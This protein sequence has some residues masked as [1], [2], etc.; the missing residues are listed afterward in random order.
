MSMLET[1]L[2][3]RPWLLADG[4]T[5]TNMFIRGLQHG[6][7]PE[8]WNLDAPDKVRDHYRSFIE[9][10]C[11]IV[12]TNT[13]G[14]TA[15]R[16]KLHGAQARVYELNKA[17]AT[18]LAE[19]TAVAGH[20][21]VCAGSAGPTGDLFQP[22]GPL[23]REDGRTAFVEQMRGLKDGGAEVAWIETMSSVEEFTAALDAAE[24]VGLPAVCT[25]SFDT[26]GRTMMGVTPAD[27]ARAMHAR[28]VRPIA[29]GGN[30]G[31]GAADLLA[32]VLSMRE[33][34]EP[35][36]VIVAKANCGIPEYVD[37]E[38]RYNGTPELM[39]DYAL[40]A[41][42]AGARIVGGCC[43]T[44]P[45]HIRAMRAALEGHEKGPVPTLA[46]VIGKLGQLTGK[47]A[48][49]LGASDGAAAA[50]SARTGRRRGRA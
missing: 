31:T 41:R 6:D 45:E 39:A 13:F 36:D 4:A 15:N 5:G 34:T 27:F 32:G 49:I 43:G 2:A 17:A 11:D 22:I 29:F 7:A 21:V 16:L 30:C 50:A 25:L 28:A 24:A 18:L 14:G 3:E 9:A 10:G 12:L 47:T 48:D 19:E 33:A 8:L 26:N 38:I 23:S 40:L 1:L 44:Q 20:P 35:G 46:Q 37:G 42:D